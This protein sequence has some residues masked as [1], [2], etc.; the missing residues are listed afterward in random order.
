MFSG[1]PLDLPSG[2]KYGIVAYPMFNVNNTAP[3]QKSM[4]ATLFKA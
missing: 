4:H 1:M 3:I 2:E